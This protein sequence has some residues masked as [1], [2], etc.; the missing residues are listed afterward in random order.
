MDNIGCIGIIR[1]SFVIR[2]ICVTGVRAKVPL[3]ER[4]MAGGLHCISLERCVKM[5]KSFID[6]VDSK[7]LYGVAVMMML[8]HHCFMVPSRL[9]GDYISIFGNYG[10]VEI[11]IAWL[12]KLCVAIYAFLSG[13]G[14]SKWARQSVTLVISPQKQFLRSCQK[15]VKQLISFYAKFWTVFLLFVPIGVLFFDKEHSLQVLLRGLFLGEYYNGEWWYMKEYLSMMVLFPLLTSVLLF[16][17]KNSI[18][19]NLIVFTAIIINV[20]FL[21]LFFWHT[22]F[23]HVF[24]WCINTFSGVYIQIFVLGFLIG[25][26]NVYEIINL[27][28]NISGLVSSIAVIAVLCGRFFYVKD[29]AQNDCDIIAIPFFI[30]F[31]VNGLHKIDARGVKTVLQ[32]IGK[33]STFMWLS[34]SFFLYYY[35]QKHILALRYS[36]LI[37]AWLLVISLFVAVL[38]DEIYKKTFALVE[39]RLLAWLVE[40]RWRGNAV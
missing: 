22:I 24:I 14:M 9:N 30:Y 1:C 18:K 6:R 26:Y 8:F 38:L 17:E 19:K 7:I 31:V 13:Y 29:P 5:E 21:R 27:R 33:Y 25:K 28:C 3:N 39:K 36:L 37:Y 35:F 12:C 4:K 10:W 40:E 32:Y 20:V 2:K 11:R 23:G 34:H 16:I 15:S